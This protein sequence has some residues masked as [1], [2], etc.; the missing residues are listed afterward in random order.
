M[1]EHV[2]VIVGDRE[3]W[4]FIYGIFHSRQAAE[5]AIHNQQDPAALG[6]WCPRIVEIP[7]DCLIEEDLL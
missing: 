5:D 7:T 6:L 1:G 3:E 4:G 2:F